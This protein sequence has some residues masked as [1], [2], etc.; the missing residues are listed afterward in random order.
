MG[1][2][3]VSAGPIAQDR[4]AHLTPRASTTEKDRTCAEGAPGR[5]YCG[6]KTKTPTAWTAVTC[7]DCHAARRADEQAGETNRW[8]K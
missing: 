2:A 3:A 1:R 8:T 6:R 4:A 5:G 7:T